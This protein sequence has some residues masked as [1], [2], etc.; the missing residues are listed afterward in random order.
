MIFLPLCILLY[1]FP[2]MNTTFVIRENILSFIIFFNALFQ[3]SFA[4]YLLTCHH[5]GQTLSS[6]LYSLLALIG[7]LRT[8]YYVFYVFTHHLF[9]YSAI[10]ELIRKMEIAIYHSPYWH[11]GVRATDTIQENK[12]ISIINSGNKKEFI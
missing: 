9:S 1:I 4:I 11:L 12:V 5:T 10:N 6:K 3:V 7:M 2:I 8:F